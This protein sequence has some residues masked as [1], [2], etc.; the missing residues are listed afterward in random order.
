MATINL[1]RVKPV[2]QGA[3]D[4]T[5]AYVVDDMVTDSGNTYICILASTGNAVTNTTYWHKMAQ[6]SDLGGLSGL[7]QGDIAYYNGTSWARLG[8]GTS[9]QYLETKGGSANP[10]WSTVTSSILHVHHFADATRNITIS[11]ASGES[12]IISFN[13]TKQVADSYLLAWGRTPNSGQNSYHAGTFMEIENTIKYDACL[14]MAPPGGAGD[15]NQHGGLFWHGLWTDITTTGS[16]TVNLGFNSRDNSSQ[17][18]SNKWNTSEATARMRAQT[19]QIT[20][21]ELDSSNHNGIT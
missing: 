1:G 18:P 2:F 5:T 12:I 21:L 19:T 7:A 16:K 8:A 14:F 3:Y 4:N 17:R 9:G 20:I 11:N 10:A 6:G 15:D 13:F